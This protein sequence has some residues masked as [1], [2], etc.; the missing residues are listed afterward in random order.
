VRDI[1]DEPPA[2]D[3]TDL[4]GDGFPAAEDC[5]DANPLVGPAAPEI[6]DGL[7]NDCDGEVDEEGCGCA[8]DDDC[9]DGWYCTGEE[10]CNVGTCQSGTSVVCDDGD[11]TTFDYCSEVSQ[12]CVSE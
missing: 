1:N 9:S 2:P 3:P 11:P 8:S 4:D 7:D 10:T 6:C 5:D 12:A